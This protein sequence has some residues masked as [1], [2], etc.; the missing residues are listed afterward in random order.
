LKKLSEKIVFRK[1]GGPKVSNPLTA[2]SKKGC[3]QSKH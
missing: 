3:R 1:I 2:N